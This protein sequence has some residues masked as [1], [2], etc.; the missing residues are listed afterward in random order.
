MRANPFAWS[1]R[2]QCLAGFLACAGLLAY[3]L[4]VQFGMLMQ[5]CPLCIL[6][7][8]AFAALGLVFLVGGLHAPKGRVGRAIYGLLAF[9]AAVALAQ[10]LLVLKKRQVEKVQAAEGI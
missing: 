8:I 9:L 2:A 6:Q 1:F 5:P 10:I 4:Y 7:R 3:A